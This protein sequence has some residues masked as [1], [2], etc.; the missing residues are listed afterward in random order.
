MIIG[1][2]LI[3]IGNKTGNIMWQILWKG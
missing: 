1:K 3:S 2:D